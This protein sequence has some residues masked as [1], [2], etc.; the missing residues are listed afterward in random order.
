MFDGHPPVLLD[1]PAP[2]RKEHDIYKHEGDG[3][4]PPDRDDDVLLF[5]E[6]FS[7][8]FALVSKHKKGLC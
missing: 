4:V 7:V 6:A 2:V 1:R 8:C 5:L 3:A